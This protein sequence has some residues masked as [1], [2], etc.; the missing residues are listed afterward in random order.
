MSRHSQKYYMTKSKEYILALEHLERNSA[1]WL[2]TGAAGFIGSNLVEKL[3]SLGQTVRGLDNFAT[4]KKENLLTVRK[5]VGEEA[6]KR[7][8]FFESDINELESCKNGCEGV[9]Y[10]LHQAAFVSVPRSFENPVMTA[11]TNVLGFLNILLAA[12]EAGVKRFIY[13]SSSSVYGDHPKLP[14]VESIIGKPLSPYAVSK[15]TNELFAHVFANNHGMPIIGLRYFN[16]FGKRQ[17]PEGEYAAVIP[18]FIKAL[19]E[20]KSPTIFGDG[21]T[22]RDFCYIDNVLQANMLAA[23]TEK[24]QAI[25]KVYNIAYGK[26]TSLNELLRVI[27][28]VI[29]EQTGWIEVLNIEP[30]HRPFRPGEIRHSLADITLAKQVLGYSP[31]FDLEQG[32]QQVVKWLLDEKQQK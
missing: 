6:W 3:L 32:L 10:I 21:E 18:K 25:N 15:Y 11:Q 27:Q 20:G 17:N 7:F 2:V 30:E 24:A 4:G 23:L 8:V 29:V 31:T 13:A 22:T 5:I 1:V 19:L 9:D 12:K 14:K 28:K 16:V 26:R